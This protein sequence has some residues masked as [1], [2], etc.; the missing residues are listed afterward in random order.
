M[1]SKYKANAKDGDGDGKVQDGTKFE[2]KVGEQLEGYKA[3]AVDG[4]ADELVQDGTDF[5]RAVEPEV[6]VASAA[7]EE[8]PEVVVEVKKETPK[9]EVVVE[10]PAPVAASPKGDK[11]EP[12]SVPTVLTSNITV[13]RGKI[14]FESLYEH[15][16]RSVGVLQ[17]RLLELGY[18]AAGS[19]NRGY[20]SD[21]TLAAVK[22]FA[23]DHGLEA[24]KIDN[25]QL[26]KAIFAGTP[27]TVG[28]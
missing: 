9:P 15:N 17:I 2:R 1:A 27:V 12:K 6:V 5:E 26:V 8:E 4:D 22:E 18:V 24:N 13:S 20:L 7:V 21:G 25:E 3:D 28:T 16:S 23:G 10:V 11:A 14:V 19:D